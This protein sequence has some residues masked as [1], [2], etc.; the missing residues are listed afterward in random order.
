MR[1]YL[2]E[3]TQRLQTAGLRA[4][5][6]FSIAPTDDLPLASGSVIIV[7]QLTSGWIYF[8]HSPEYHDQQPNPLD[9]YAKR[10]C[11]SI[12]TTI[13]GQVIMPNDSR[14]DGSYYPFLQWAQRAEAVT[15]SA[16]GLLIHPEFGLWQAYRAA[17]LIPHKLPQKEK[18][19]EATSPSPCQT[20]HQPCLSACP[21]DA[22]TPE[23]YD[24]NA[25]KAYLNT[26]SAIC[27]DRGCLARVA[28][29]VGKS[30]EYQQTQ[31]HFL[32]QKFS[33][34]STNALTKD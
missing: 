23:G 25:C 18:Q 15:P 28:C 27:H 3:I 5:G 19:R 17:I 7:G 4:C 10:L 24:V 13:N 9:R 16:L 33:G 14:I 2:T 1:D 20:C 32:M 29:P 31:K 22:F 34:Q 12:A 21:V 6:Y 26:T 11:Q 30:Y 8:E